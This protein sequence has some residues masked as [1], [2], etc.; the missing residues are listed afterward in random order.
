MALRCT[1]WLYLFLFVSMYVPKN[2]GRCSLERFFSISKETKLS[3]K[4]TSHE[5]QRTRFS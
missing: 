5:T 3:P 1:I 4:K 2:V